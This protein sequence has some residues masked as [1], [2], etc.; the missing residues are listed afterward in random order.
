MGC[1]LFDTC[2]DSATRHVARLELL[3]READHRIANSLQLAS[4]AVE[5]EA[6]ALG[7]PA[8]KAGLT[9]AQRHIEAIAGVHSLLSLG[10]AA[11]TIPLHDYLT[12]LVAGLRRA[13]ANG[14]ES[15]SI[16]LSCARLDVPSKLAV[17]IGMI[18]N[19]L[20]GNACKYA[21][22]PG[23][24]GEVRV[25][26]EALE[27]GFALRVEDD[28]RGID[29]HTKPEGSGLGVSMIR[30]MVRHI[31]GEFRYQERAVGTRAIVQG[32]VS[33]LPPSSENLP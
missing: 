15:R 33:S 29:V 25:R 14:Q 8:A 2:D 5:R 19:E 20:V 1:S 7:D 4:A 27:E 13:M 9:A 10:R 11:G 30:A 21:Y 12:R 26:L 32:P 31:G 24:P 16:S 23:E 3:L 6:R 22:R 18:V 17:C 28:G